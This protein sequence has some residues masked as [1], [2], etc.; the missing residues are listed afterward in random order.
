MDCSHL[1]GMYLSIVHAAHL[2]AYHLQHVQLYTCRCAGFTGDPSRLVDGQC[3]SLVQGSADS[4]QCRRAGSHRTQC[5]RTG[6][7][8]C[9][10]SRRGQI[11]SSSHLLLL[12]HIGEHVFDLLHV[13][14]VLSLLPFSSESENYGKSRLLL[15]G[16]CVPTVHIPEEFLVLTGSRLVFPGTL[17]YHLYYQRRSPRLW[18]VSYVNTSPCSIRQAC[19]SILFVGH[20]DSCVLWAEYNYSSV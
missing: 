4:G 3:A 16:S 11:S 2:S 6:P 17:W 1:G 10:R 13:P 20:S 19:R 5:G 15:P 12:M 14:L 18:R 9:R 7:P 8:G